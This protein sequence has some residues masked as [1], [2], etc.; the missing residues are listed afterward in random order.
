[1][2]ERPHILPLS[3]RVRWI[4]IG[5]TAVAVLGLGVALWIPLGACPDGG[6]YTTYGDGQASCMT[7]DVG[8]AARA[9][10]PQRIGIAIVSGLLAVGLVAFLVRRHRVGAD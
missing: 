5:A 4:V 7:S 8:Y 10:T 6:T 3:T 9:L 1:M 2:R